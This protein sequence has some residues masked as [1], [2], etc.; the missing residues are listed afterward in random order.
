MGMFFGRKCKRRGVFLSRKHVFHQRIARKRVSFFFQKI[1]KRKGTV[2]ETP[3]AHPHTLKIR[4]VPPP[5]YSY[6][7]VLVLGKIG[8]C[9]HVDILEKGCLFFKKNCKRKG[10]V[11]ETPLAHPCTLKI[12]QVPPPPG[13][14]PCP[15]Q[16]RSLSSCGHFRHEDI[17]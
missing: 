5:G 10:T 12:R 2:S 7:H 16:N 17:L 6:A 13:Y 9:S 1:C 14:R 11:S 3:L 4:Q 8:P 15:C